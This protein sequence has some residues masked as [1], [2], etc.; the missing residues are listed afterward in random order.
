MLSKSARYHWDAEAVRVSQVSIAP[1]GN[2]FKRAD[3]LSYLSD[4]GP[5]GNDAPWRPSSCGRNFRST[6]LFAASLDAMIARQRARLHEL[7]AIRASGGLLTDDDGAPLALL[8]NTGGGD[9]WTT[10]KHYATFP[11]ALIRP[12]IRGGASAAGCCPQCGAPWARDVT[13][14]SN[15]RQRESAHQPGAC[16]DKVDSSH[17]A[18]P[19]IIDRGWRPTC[20]CGVAD[21]IPCLVLDPFAGMAT[22]A[23]EAKAQGL[24][25]VMIEG[26]PKYAADSENRV[27]RAREQ[28]VEREGEAVQIKSQQLELI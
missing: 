21:P 19:T 3:R 15:Y 13:R 9:E 16:P 12:L 8:A 24:R 20:G 18:P 1:S 6:D 5:R 28:Q 11:R 22:V 23:V 25:Y 26:N 17:W 14:Q 7:L 2:G 27:A 4:D 10:G